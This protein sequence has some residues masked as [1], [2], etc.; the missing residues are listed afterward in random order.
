MQGIRDIGMTPILRD[1]ETK[2]HSSFEEC[3]SEMC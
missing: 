3:R 2:K 1:E